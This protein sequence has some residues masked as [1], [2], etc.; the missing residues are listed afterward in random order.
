MGCYTIKYY[1]HPKGTIIKFVIHNKTTGQTYIGIDNKTPTYYDDI[2]IEIDPYIEMLLTDGKY[3]LS[4]SKSRV[5]ISFAYS[6][7]ITFSVACDLQKKSAC[8]AW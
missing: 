4:D 8:C 5:T 3:S 6:S 7:L 2:G 1:L